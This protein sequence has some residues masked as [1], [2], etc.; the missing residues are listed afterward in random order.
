MTLL[1]YRWIL[2]FTLILITASM[3]IGLGASQPDN[4]ILENEQ[5]WETYCVGGTCISGGNNLFIGDVGGDLQP[6]IITGGSTYNL[7]PDG[8]TSNREAPLRLWSWN[9]ANLTLEATQNWPGNINSIYAGDLD[10]DSQQELLTGG[11]ISN[12]SGTYSALSVWQWKDSSL[13]LKARIVNVS[14]TAITVNDLD[15]DEVPEIITVGRFNTTGQYGSRI[16]LWHLEEDHLVSKGSINWCIANNTSVSS[17]ATQDLDNDGKIEIVTAG[18]ANDLKNSSGNLRIWQYDGQTLALKANQEWRL[19]EG[20]YGLT[21]AGGIQG[22]TAVNNLKIGDVD[23]DGKNEIVTGGFA[24]DGQ[25]VNAQLRIWDWNDQTLVLEKSEEWATDY[26]TEVKS[27]SLNDLD[28]DSTVEIVTSGITAAAGSFSATS[29]TPEKAELRVWTWDGKTLNMKQSKEWTI[30][31]GACG[32]NVATGD[33]DNDGVMEIVTVGC[34]YFSNLCDPDM[35]IWSLPTANAN[36]AV[37]YIAVVGSALA[38]VIVG[39]LLAL[40]RRK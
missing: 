21:I 29:T 2:C 31:E 33:V 30:D 23:S 38:A 36:P 8:T 16:D 37:L 26:L 17:V 9:G 4:F 28:K 10:H 7:L 27:I 35:R 34:T 14:I 25:K 40:K 32:W 6:E 39:V 3:H 1:V 12:N 15:K 5:H 18:Y 11:T 22:N 20:V 13:S 19:V 24:Y